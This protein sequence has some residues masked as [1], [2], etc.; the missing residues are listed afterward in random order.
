MSYYAKKLNIKERDLYLPDKYDHIPNALGD[1]SVDDLV[2]MTTELSMYYIEKILGEDPKKF[3]YPRGS[4]LDL[5]NGGFQKLWMH[6]PKLPIWCEENVAGS[7]V[8]TL[9]EPENATLRNNEELS[10]EGVRLLHKLADAQAVRRRRDYGVEWL[11]RNIKGGENILIA[12]SGNN[13]PYLE[14]LKN[15]PEER[16]PE[17]AVAL[18]YSFTDLNRSKDIANEM[19]LGGEP[20][21]YMWRNLIDKKG[22]TKRQMIAGVMP[23]I[24][25][26]PYVIKQPRGEIYGDADLREESFDIIKID[27]WLEYWPNDKIANHLGEYLKLLRPG[28]KLIFN[29][30]RGD[31]H[32]NPHFIRTVVGWT[33][34][35]LRDMDQM[36]DKVLLPNADTIAKV[37]VVNID[38]SLRMVELTKES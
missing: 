13:I 2:S 8:A 6:V 38:D 17:S 35:A 29:D 22:F 12:P 16:R 30:V 19:G 36:H 1:M 26:A 11:T 21:K 27:G 14:A 18:D 25:L 5:N 33:P 37:D 24:L 31:T 23:K 7:R 15:L 4:K 9:Y 28:G 10:K 32:P 20:I 34:Y 3:A